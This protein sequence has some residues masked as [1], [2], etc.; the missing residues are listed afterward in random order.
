MQERTPEPASTEA[1][2][3]SAKST[4]AEADGLDHQAVEEAVQYVL[5]DCF[6]AVGQTIGMRMTVDYEAVVWWHDHFRAKFVAAM[7][8]HRRIEKM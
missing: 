4:G 8:R 2:G 1:L 6:F 3:R 5:A 7:H